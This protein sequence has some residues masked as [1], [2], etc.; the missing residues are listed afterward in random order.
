LVQIGE[1]K[2]TMIQVKNVIKRDGTIEKFT[3]DKL[4]KWELWSSENVKD[5]LDWSN[6]TLEVL[7]SLPETTT[8]INIQNKLIEAC[9]RRKTWPYSIMAGRLFASILYKEMYKND[10]PTIKYLHNQ[11]IDIGLMIDLKYTTEEYAIIENIIDHN[12]DNKLS[13]IQI[14]QLVNKYGVSNKINNIKYETPQ[15]VFIRMAMAIA[16]NEPNCKKIEVVTK[17][18]KYFSESKLSAPTP[19]YS[20]TG[21][22]SNGFVSCCLYTSGDNAASIA[23]GDHIAYTMTYMSAGIGGFTNCRSINDNVRN[24][25]IKHQG[26]LPYIK[27]LGSNVHANLQGGRGGACTNYFSCFDPEVIDIIN[28]QNPKT[29]I[30][31]QNRDIHQAFIFN[32]LFVEKVYKDEDI[33]TFNIYTAPDLMEC[34]F[35]SD[36]E[37]FKK[38]YTQYEDD[39]TFK[40]NYIRARDIAITA[41]KQ[42]HEV[43]TLYMIQIDE[44][45]RHTSYLDSIYSS[46][47]CL[48]ITQPTKHYNSMLDLYSNDDH[49]R[50]EVSICALAGIVAPNIESDEEYEDVM[51]YALKLID[52]SIYNT[53]FVFPHLKFTTKARMNAGV[54]II[55]LAYDLARNNLKYTSKEG[56]DRVSYISERH[57]YFAIKAS[58]KLGKEIGNAPWMHKTKWPNGWL[59]IDTGNTTDYKYKYD[60]EKLRSDI[61]EN[62][63]IHNSSL[64][65][66]QP[67]ESSSKAT[68]MPNGIYPIRDLYLFKTDL[69]NAVDWVAIDN[70]ILKDKYE[71]AWNISF[72]ELC[73]VYSRVQHFTDQSISADFYKDR[74]INKELKASDLLDELYSMYK[75]KIKTRYYTNTRTLDPVTLDTIETSFNRGCSSGACSL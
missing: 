52:F 71:F 2:I 12:K 60:W 10:I 25:A 23:I 35:T 3:A 55:G 8:S 9:N 46:N 14:Y 15:F 66:L 65:A 40:K 74:T 1:I 45:N 61:I 28:I 21:T 47:L 27:V 48:E 37:K 67:T 7:K 20:N 30:F 32:K 63:G 19:V 68:G 50:G 72:Q 56:L 42:C 36:S 75:Y 4:I 54:G 34:L 64:V 33:F 24:G 49:D 5:R 11:L 31:K 22:K 57:S 26:K 39:I 73:E 6:L 44:V 53:D 43:A 17:L 29:P 51:Y 13:Y 70:D 18:Y 41:L 62:K 16:A 69:S 58:L 59:P 38:L